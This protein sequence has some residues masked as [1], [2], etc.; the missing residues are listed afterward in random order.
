MSVA[1]IVSM[2]RQQTAGMYSISGRQVGAMI[3][4]GHLFRVGRVVEA[5]DRRA[6]DG[7]RRGLRKDWGGRARVLEALS[8]GRPMTKSEIMAAAKIGSSFAT[9]A[10]LHKLYYGGLVKRVARGTYQVEVPS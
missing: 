8:D 5:D 7:T 9:T 10:L 1:R 4:A 3:K 2:C 6:S